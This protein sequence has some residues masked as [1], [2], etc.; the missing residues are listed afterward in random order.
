METSTTGILSTEEN[1]KIVA[2]GVQARTTTELKTRRN[3]GVKV[4]SQLTPLP[5]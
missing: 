1:F 2:R 5:P 4:N 3:D